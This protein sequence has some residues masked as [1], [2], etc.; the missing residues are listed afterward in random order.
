MHNPVDWKALTKPMDFAHLTQPSHIIMACTAWKETSDGVLFTCTTS[1]NRNAY[2]MITAVHDKVIRTRMSIS[3]ITDKKSDILVDDAQNSCGFASIKTDPQ[4]IGTLLLYTATLTVTVRMD[5]WNIAI[6]DNDQSPPFFAQQT[7]DRCFGPQ[8]ESAPI[9]FDLSPDGSLYARDTI[10]LHPGEHCYGFGERFSRLDKT[11]QSIDIWASD[12]GSVQSN[13]SY[14]A[15]PFMLSSQGYGLLVHTSFPSRF[16][17]AVESGG[18]YTFSIA[19][20]YLDYFIIRGPLYKTI[21][22]KYADLTGYAPVPPKWS[23]GFWLSRCSYRSRS[24]IEEVVCRMQEEHIPVDVISID[25]WWQGDS[26]WCS[27]QW[28]NT[29]FPNHQEFIQKL[30]T[31]GIRTCLWITPYIP[32]GTPLYAE[33]LQKGFFLR[34]AFGQIASVQEDFSGQSL[35]AIDFTEPLQTQWFLDKLEILLQEGVAVFKTDFGEQAPM[36]AVYA[37]GRTGLEM[38]NLYPLLYNAAVF[39]LTKKVFGIGL[40]W[41]R[42]GYLGSQRYPVQWGGDSYASF[43]QMHGQLRGLLG[44][45]LSGVPFCSHDIGGFDYEP[46]YFSRFDEQQQKNEAVALGDNPAF[47]P[48]N[49]RNTPPDAILYIRWMQFGIFSSHSRSHGKRKHEPW[50]YGSEAKRISADFIRF[51]YRLLPYIYSQAVTSARLGLPMVRPMVLEYQHDRCTWDLDTQ[52]LFGTDLLVAPVFNPEGRADIYFPAGSWCC[53]WTNETVTGPC[54]RSFTVPLDQIPL[55]IRA[56]SLIPL[57][58]P[59]QYVDSIHCDH[60]D[61]LAFQPVEG[62]ELEIYDEGADLLPYARTTIRI[63]REDAEW[64]VQSSTPGIGCTLLR[65]EIC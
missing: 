27:Y 17:L 32:Q 58:P 41:G 2:I 21:L 35:A 38:H 5:R 15:M 11:N 23:F 13:R 10:A 43:S 64:Q 63:S 56:G 61:I 34:D 1:G 51:R 33:G 55:W 31:M 30:K 54:W 60:Y 37:D 6:S 3:P 12:A 40:T 29:H 48:D 22:A 20:S 42:S 18:A 49:L 59:M 44:Y 16:N 47:S 53:F 9:G 52:Y 46:R 62:A 24:E 57:G 14:K 39:N 45:G 26:P 8:F 4:N 28:D 7:Q 50:E 65:R 36:N 25:P 19:D